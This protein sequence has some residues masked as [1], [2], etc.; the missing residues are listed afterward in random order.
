MA[1][2][3]L[4][5][6]D[7]DRI[8][9]YV[10]ATDK[11][12][13]V[14]G[15]SRLLDRLNRETTWQ[16]I[17]AIYPGLPEAGGVYFAG[18]SGAVLVPEDKVKAVINAI[19]EMYRRAT[20]SAS[21]TGVPVPLAP[22]TR[23][24]GFGKRMEFAALELRRRKDEKA[25]R[26]ALTIEPYTQPC[27]ACERYPAMRVSPLDHQPI[28]DACHAKREAFRNASGAHAELSEIGKLAYPPGYVGFIYAD[29][30]NIGALLNKMEGVENYRKFAQELD[31]LIVKTTVRDVLGKYSASGTG[32]TRPYEELL[33]G[34]DD[35]MVVT[36]GDIALPV[37][38]KMARAFEQGSAQVLRRAQVKD[39]QQ[40]TLG[41]SVVI[42]HDSFPM[43][44][45]YRLASQLVKRAK[46]RCAELDYATSA[47]DFMV[48]TAAGSSDVST[49][50]K[51]S[52]SEQ[53][54]VFPHV[55]LHA[56]LTQRPYTLDEADKLI[57][58]A[59]DFKQQNFPTSQLHFL[60][61]GIFHSLSEAAFRW[62]KVAG[63]AK[64]EHVK[65][66]EDF[67]KA[68]SAG[69]TLLPP[70]RGGYTAE[71]EREY[72]TSFADLVEIYPFV[73]SAGKEAS[74]VALKD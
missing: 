35:L 20:F 55:N 42:A 53:A 31:A 63:R 6:F 15:A 34:G 39:V 32:G 47:I 58:F 3:Y 28:C 30:N 72:I 17:K 22:A 57:E 66:M 14:C 68:F 13:E 8:K 26:T 50:R 45:F 1:E 51:E 43:A 48:V 10:F 16:T 40:L 56:R 2:E 71:G 74:D 9:E 67:H 12:R 59:R 61:E 36:A 37:A 25:N 7:T 29:G 24:S 73:H 5:S 64:K 65:L 60:Y 23:E 54:F 69:E 18:G 52:L 49:T 41:I 62:R 21:I 19:E 4:V 44:A 46:Q 33:V 27:A 38:L 11:L 70:W